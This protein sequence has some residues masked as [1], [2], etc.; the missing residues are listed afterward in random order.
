MDFTK[1]V[2]D[3]GPHIFLH[4]LVDILPEKGS[5]ASEDL[6]HN[7][8]GGENVTLRIIRLVF[9]DFWGHVSW[10]SASFEENFRVVHELGE[11]EIDN[12]D[13]ET[14]LVGEHYVFGFDIS[15]NDVD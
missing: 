1:I 7:D 14:V 6:I 15:V 10:S 9:Q 12:F 2:A 4:N 8:P 13:F 5:A 3:L 11:T